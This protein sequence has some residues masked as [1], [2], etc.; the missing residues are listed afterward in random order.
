MGKI[1]NLKELQRVYDIPL[2][3]LIKEGF[4]K[5]RERN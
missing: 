2:S 4:I 5:E 3:P 1:R